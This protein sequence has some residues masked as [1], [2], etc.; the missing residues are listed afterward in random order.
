M[1]FLKT[2]IMLLVLFK[3]IIIFL[4]LII[5]L[6]ISIA[7]YTLAERKL[8][9]SFQRRVGPNVVGFFGLLQPFADGLKLLTKE[10]I[11]PKNS[12]KILFIVSPCFML[13]L[14][15]IS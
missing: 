9:S 10:I 5:P 11:F 12:N 8:L 1:I 13:I 14:S 4:S 15:F 6:L 7:F 3:I 2:K